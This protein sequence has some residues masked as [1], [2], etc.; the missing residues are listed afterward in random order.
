M[1][2]P[3]VLRFVGDTSHLTRT[4]NATA[5]QS[6]ALSRQVGA[7]NTQ[8]AAAS[9]GLIATGS[10]VSR[11]FTLPIAYAT[12]ASAILATSFESAMVKIETLAGES[13][14]Q[15]EEWTESVLELARVLPQ[16]PAELAEG[17]YFIASSGIDAS[18]A[19]DVLKASAKA[20][21]VGLGDT[22][23]VADALTSAINAYGI[24]N[25]KAADAAD[26]LLRAV[27]EGK[28]EAEDFAGS[29]GRVIAPAQLLGVT[30]DEVAAAMSSMTLVGLS[31]DE[32]ATALR[33]VFFTLAKPSRQVAKALAEVGLSADEVRKS[34]DEKGLLATLV[35]LRDKVGDNDE[36]LA[37]MFPNIRAFNGL[38]I[39][40]GENLSNTARIFEAMGNSTGLVDKAFQRTSETAEFKFN[41]ALN[42]VKIV[43]TDIGASVL[44]RLVESVSG[45]TETLLRGWESLSP[46][47]QSMVINIALVVA[48]LGPM[49]RLIGNIGAALNLIAAHPV[50]AAIVALAAGFYIAYQRIEWFRNAVDAVVRFLRDNLQEVLI[51]IGSLIA[52]T[53][54]PAFSPLIALAGTL[55]M[56]Y[57]RFEPFREAVN[58]LARLLMGAFRS[59]VEWLRDFA[60]VAWRSMQQA[61]A[62]AVRVAQSALNGLVRGFQV[63]RSGVQPIVD[64]FVRWVAPV[65]GE[66]LGLMG[67]LSSKFARDFMAA[68][69]LAVDV[70]G[71]IIETLSDV[72]TGLAST[73]AAVLGSAVIPIIQGVVG[74]IW[75]LRVVVVA[76]FE[77]IVSVLQGFWKVAQPLLSLI[78]S[79]VKSVFTGAFGVAKSIVEGFLQTLRGIIQVIRG[80]INGDWRQIWEGMRNTFA[81]IW[82]GVTGSVRTAVDT[83][84]GFIRNLP[85]R[86]GRLLE[87]IR[88]AGL[89]IGGKFISGIVDGVKGIASAAFD[90][91]KGFTEALVEALKTGWNRIVSW[92]NEK[93]NG[94]EIDLPVG[95]TFGLPDNMWNA[96]RLAN[97]GIFSSPVFAQIA[98]A[99]EE[100]VVPL[101]R[102]RR[103]AAILRE[104][105]LLPDGATLSGEDKGAA[106]VVNQT[107]YALDPYEAARQAGIEARWA[108]KTTGR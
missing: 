67:D 4:F 49:L 51:A 93:T 1:A 43:G 108:M 31:A 106:V 66:A 13:S 73:I 88:Q 80:I 33:Q 105:G 19:L 54:L 28:G 27:Q 72:F 8:L 91:G 74:A 50:I 59:A 89:D 96:L 24:E 103:A 14:A 97:G 16:S 63:V 52:S 25:L 84:V 38:T 21:A 9:Q 34:I 7:M 100:A 83:I 86:L 98:E 85:S 12:G 76:A 48:A 29:I 39:M 40:T 99:G 60:P 104:A 36:L 92:L 78:G 47:A 95:P 26:I 57:Q 22:Q 90:I 17:L 37:N 20:S 62:G 6:A 44:P 58:A 101:T 45:F 70:G 64:W 15:V 71:P 81:G 30:F 11:R 35:D 2:R 87:S 82:H 69:Q 77:V 102:P 41:K 42:R 94:I 5:A 46:G 65:F 55:Y 18:H 61:A 56:A 3:V 68:F 53:L 23:T 32:S 79:T 75:E 107:I 10:I